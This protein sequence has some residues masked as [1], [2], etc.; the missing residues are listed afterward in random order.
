MPESR[1]ISP[2]TVSLTVFG[3]GEFRTHVKLAL[4]VM[5]VPNLVR[6]S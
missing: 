3:E 4:G 5:Y 6:L 2:G 1:R